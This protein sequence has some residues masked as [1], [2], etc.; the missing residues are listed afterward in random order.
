MYRRLAIAVLLATDVVAVRLFSPSWA[1]LVRGVP[2]PHR[3]AA[4]VGADR[5][6][7]V[8][9]AAALW[10]AAVWFGI[11]LLAALCR[12]L[13]GAAGRAADVLAHRTLPAALYRL[14]ASAVG[15]SVVVAP[16][17]V[18]TAAIAA[19][20]PPGVS[21]VT[22]VPHPPP[23]VWPTDGPLPPPAWPQGTN[24]TAT[25]PATPP[26][27]VR[28]VPPATQGSNSSP[29]RGEVTVRPGDSLWL[30][31]ARRLGAGATPRQIDAAWREWYATNR[32]LI[33]ADPNVIHPG[34]VLVDPGGC[35]TSATSTEEAP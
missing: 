17:T 10:L 14:C 11:G 34:Q 26:P 2:A 31:A 9:A 25:P 35:G 13:P 16:I 32:A 3:W 29:A 1:A 15:V 6:V 24:A 28:T 5:M 21:E 19:E 23:P 8:L 4:R 27:Q 20:R 22:A 30:I 18:G 12:A 33:G 7:L